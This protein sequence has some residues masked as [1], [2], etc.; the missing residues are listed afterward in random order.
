MSPTSQRLQLLEP[1]DKWD[2]K[3]LEDMLILIKVKTEGS[4]E[5]HFLERALLL[6]QLKM[7]CLLAGIYVFRAD[8]NNRTHSVEATAAPGRTG[9]GRSHGEPPFS[10]KVV[11]GIP[12]FSR[13]LL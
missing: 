12:Q 7:C 9:K 10:C 8:L 6:S 3:D 5:V 2:G 4:L 13:T 1:F 11:H